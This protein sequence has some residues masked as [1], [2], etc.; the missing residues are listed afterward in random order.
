LPASAPGDVVEE[1]LHEIA[2]SV[3]ATTNRVR[4]TADA[5]SSSLE[6]RRGRRLRRNRPEVLVKWRH[7]H[8][9]L[10][11]QRPVLG[12]LHPNIS[13]DDVPGTGTFS[14]AAL[15]ACL[16]LA[17]AS[18]AGQDGAHDGGEQ[19]CIPVLG[20]LVVSQEAQSS[21]EDGWTMS[22]SFGTICAHA[23]VF[24]LTMS[25]GSGPFSG[26]L[27]LDYQTE[28]VGHEVQTWNCD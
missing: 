13:L 16:S 21:C 3:Q 18:D 22:E 10:D 17:V 1:L 7:R 28:I 11:F 8:G 27:S 4:G 9:E 15:G 25:P 14:L 20:T 19:N 12:G 26:T 2:T 6:W 23:F 5:S 24:D